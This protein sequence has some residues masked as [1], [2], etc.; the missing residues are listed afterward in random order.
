I[1]DATPLGAVLEADLSDQL[2]ALEAL[3]DAISSADHEEERACHTGRDLGEASGRVHRACARLDGKRYQ[4][5]NAEECDGIWAASEFRPR[6]FASRVARTHGI[7]SRKARQTVQLARELRDDI[8]EFGD[9][10]RAGTIGPDQVDALA[11]TALT[12][13][14]RIAALSERVSLEPGSD[15]PDHQGVPETENESE[16]PADGSDSP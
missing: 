11:S 4:W 10:L 14:A 12:A 5:L 3:V 16:S 13:P 8:P 2:A 6:T 9:A 1:T 15:A 7:P